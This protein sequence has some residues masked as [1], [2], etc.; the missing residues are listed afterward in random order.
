L[1]RPEEQG[2]L[3]AEE[4]PSAYAEALVSLL[5]N[6]AKALSLGQAARLRVTAEFSLSAVIRRYAS[7]YN[8][9]VGNPHG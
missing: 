4:D 9:A 8:G 3:V 6:H 1:I 7:V 5:E 2:I